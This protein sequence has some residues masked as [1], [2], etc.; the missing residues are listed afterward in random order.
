MLR[1]AFAADA[2]RFAYIAVLADNLP[3]R[4]VIESEG[5]E[6]QQSFFLQRILGIERKWAGPMVGRGP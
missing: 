5:F 4:R 2:T 6:F 1:A 3:S